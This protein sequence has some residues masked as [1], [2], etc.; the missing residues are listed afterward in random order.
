MCQ[1]EVSDVV[2]ATKFHCI[3]SAANRWYRGAMFASSPEGRQFDPSWGSISGRYQWVLRLA[4]PP[5]GR[6]TNSH[7]SSSVTL[8]EAFRLS[9][10]TWRRTL[11]SSSA[12]GHTLSEHDSVATG[13]M[14]PRTT[15]RLSVCA[16]VMMLG[17]GF[18]IEEAR[19]KKGPH[20][21]LYVFAV[22][23]EADCS[24]ITHSLVVS[25]HVSKCLPVGS[26]GFDSQ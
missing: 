23:R 2:V 12:M 25:G 7:S 26:P 8:I 19:S 20:V 14:L 4:I 11:L 6:R 21:L 1:V 10:G 16:R 5:H 15:I 17:K 3:I 24:H 22:R 9:M 13:I 18:G